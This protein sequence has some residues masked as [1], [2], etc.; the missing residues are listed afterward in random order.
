MTKK[1]VSILNT[2]YVVV[3]R[4][5]SQ[6]IYSHERYCDV[7]G[8]LLSPI[9]RLTHLMARGIRDEDR[10]KTVTPLKR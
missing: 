2:H 10:F 9:V 4:G 7:G 6:Y 8:I 3:I 5:L 1:Y